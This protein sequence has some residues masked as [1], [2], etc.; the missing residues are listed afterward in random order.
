MRNLHTKGGMNKLELINELGRKAG[1]AKPEARRIVLT[2]FDA[3]SNTLAKGGRAEIRGFCSFSVKKYKGYTGRNPKTGKKM[4]IKQKKL[5]F[6]KCGKQF[7]ER[8]DFEV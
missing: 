4:K 1:I 5:P 8:V 2:F 3:I 7:K 6:F